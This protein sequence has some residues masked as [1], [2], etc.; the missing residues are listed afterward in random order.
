MTQQYGEFEN[1]FIKAQEGSMSEQ[2]K[3]LFNQLLELPENQQA[4][5][6]M[7]KVNCALMQLEMP[8]SSY[9][10]PPV[11]KFD[12]NLWLELVNKENMAPAIET[13]ICDTVKPVGKVKIIPAAFLSFALSVAAVLMIMLSVHFF[14]LSG[15]NGSAKLVDTMDV[16]WSNA[17]IPGIG[18]ELTRVRGGYKLSSGVVKMLFDSGAQVVVESPAEFEIVSGNEMKLNSGSIFAKVPTQ[19]IGFTVVTPKCS[20]IDLGTE[21]GVKL[22]KDGSTELHVNRGRTMLIDA[23]SNTE[24]EVL[25]GSAVKVSNDRVVS[26]ITCQ[27]QLFAR[28]IISDAGIVWRGGTKLSMA[29]IVGG[30]NGWGTGKAETAINPATG[31]FG[32]YSAFTRQADGAY[33]KVDSGKKSYIDGVFV[34]AGPFQ[35]VT[36]RGDKFNECPETNGTYYAEIINGA[37]LNLSGNADAN[38]LKLGN[39]NYGTADYPAIVMHPNVGI[40]F[41]LENIT[42]EVP[43][44]KVSRFTADVGLSSAMVRSNHYSS[45]VPRESNAVVWLLIDGKVVFSAKLDNPQEVKQIDIEI[46]ETAKYLTLVTTDAKGKGDNEFLNGLYPDSSWCIVAKPELVMSAR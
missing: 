40:T 25:A 43:D 11:S 42:S 27:P 18:S 17:S 19:A 13:D 5:F 44:G 7:V 31:K 38:M 23:S 46:P 21:F 32:S 41:D 28:D 36:S 8:D 35:V 29:D 1:L 4:F 24:R 12:I 3:E 15:N 16:G 34:P 37:G 14:T 20:V 6:E 39:K 30:G 2:E 45:V 9:A 22:L 26:D 33:V 10:Q